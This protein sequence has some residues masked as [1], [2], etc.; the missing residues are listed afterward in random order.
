MD[1]MGASENQPSLCFFWINGVDSWLFAMLYVV[2]FYAT[3]YGASPTNTGLTWW[4]QAGP[5]GKKTH[6]KHGDW[7]H[8]GNSWHLTEK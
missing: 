6:M 3:S 7:S 4:I 5:N 1:R 8:R 2:V